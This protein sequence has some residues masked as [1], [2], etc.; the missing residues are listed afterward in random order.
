MP[1]EL[2][3]YLAVRRLKTSVKKVELV[4]RAFAAFELK[5]EIVA[6]S[7][8]GLNINMGSCYRDL[9]SLI[10]MELKLKNI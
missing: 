7:E 1:L 4:A 10:Q 6:S 3:D 5:L 9:K 8:E 2:A